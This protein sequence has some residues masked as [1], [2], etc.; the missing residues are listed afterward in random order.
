LLIVPIDAGHWPVF[1]CNRLLVTKSIL[2]ECIALGAKAKR[3]RCPLLEDLWAEDD[4]LWLRA[5]ARQIEFED[6]LAKR[7]TNLRRNEA[8]QPVFE[9]KDFTCY[10]E[11]EIRAFAFDMR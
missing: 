5:P 2:N 10:A 8:S 7:Q 4:S 11:D 9:E 1:S 6:M 3:D